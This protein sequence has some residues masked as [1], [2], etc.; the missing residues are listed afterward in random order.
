M[1]HNSEKSLESVAGRIPIVVVEQGRKLLNRTA[2]TA[3]STAKTVAR[4]G[5]RFVGVTVDRTERYARR[6]P[7]M[8]IGGA[9]CT[10]ACLGALLTFLF[11][12]D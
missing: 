9:A 7:W 1:R 5:R 3:G 4:Q 11:L 6:N 2:R 8:G 12:R 10:G